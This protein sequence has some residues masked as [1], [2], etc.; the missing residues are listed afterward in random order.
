MTVFQM[1]WKGHS[2]E[3]LAAARADEQIFFS[4]HSAAEKRDEQWVIMVDGE[5]ARTFVATHGPN[6]R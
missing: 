6:S 1:P 3:L 5:E 4:D 2:A